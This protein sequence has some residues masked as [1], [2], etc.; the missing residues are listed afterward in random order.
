MHSITIEEL[1]KVLDKLPNHKSSG[2]DGLSYEA[3]KATLQFL[4]QFLPASLIIAYQQVLYV[5]VAPLHLL[6]HFI[7][8]GINLTLKIGDQSP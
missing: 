5:Q 3:Y 2:P 4:P 8:K 1:E 7:K 6:S